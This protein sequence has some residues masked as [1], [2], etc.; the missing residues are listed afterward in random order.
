MRLYVHVYIH[1]VSVQSTHDRS[2]I[3]TYKDSS[4]MSPSA[5]K[6]WCSELDINVYREGPVG[7]ECTIAFGMD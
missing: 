1:P 6:I 4:V 3:Y 5:C 7:K 2:H